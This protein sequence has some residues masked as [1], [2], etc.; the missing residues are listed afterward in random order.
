MRCCAISNAV[1]R[2]FMI[3]TIFFGYGKPASS[4]LSSS[5]AAT[6]LY[7]PMPNY[8]AK[9]DVEAAKKMLDDLL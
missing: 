8:P 6:D 3:D 1:D 7:K 9:G 5:F 2:Q 4:A